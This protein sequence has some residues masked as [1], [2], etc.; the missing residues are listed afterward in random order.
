MSD[1]IDQVLVNPEQYSP[2]QLQAFR[3]LTEQSLNSYRADLSL[4][5]VLDY[6]MENKVNFGAQTGSILAIYNEMSENHEAEI[7]KH[8]HFLSEG[9]QRIDQQLQSVTSEQ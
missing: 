7:Q 2:A 1:S 6:F 5:S 3:L 8:I 9:L 4:L